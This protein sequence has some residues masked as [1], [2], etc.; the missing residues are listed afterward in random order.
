LVWACRPEL[1]LPLI[2]EAG[3][4]WA[5]RVAVVQPIN[6]AT[7]KREVILR[8]HYKQVVS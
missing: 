4:S 3:C 6:A 7:N 2:G 1:E 8:F 5:R